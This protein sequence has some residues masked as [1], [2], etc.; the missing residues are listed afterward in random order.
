MARPAAASAVLQRAGDALRAVHGLEVNVTDSAVTWRRR[1]GLSGV[2]FV[3]S[4]DRF[5]LAVATGSSPRALELRITHHRCHFTSTAL[6]L[7]FGLF[8]GREGPW[9]LQAGLFTFAWF[10][11]AG[12]HYVR[13]GT[14]PRAF[15]NRH[16]ASF[17]L[18][19]V[20]RGVG[21]GVPESLN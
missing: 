7:V 12:G 6:A 2:A 13:G 1:P 14:W 11:L 4:L 19:I 21:A 10:W 9:E 20:P 3:D 17:D 8:L 15:I 16:G 18:P 5:S